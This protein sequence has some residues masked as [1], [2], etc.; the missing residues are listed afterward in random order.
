MQQG[1]NWSRLAQHS[2]CVH[3]N[4]AGL[5]HRGVLRGMQRECA[6]DIGVDLG[7][8]SAMGPEWV[9]RVIMD[10]AHRCYLVPGI[11]HSGLSSAVRVNACVRMRMR[12]LWKGGGTGMAPIPAMAMASTSPLGRGARVYLNRDIG[13]HQVSGVVGRVIWAQ[14]IRPGGHICS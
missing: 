5:S 8:H 2:L 11:G 6:V 3:R 9:P 14:F 7:V 12:G 1:H 10:I 13:P 4:R